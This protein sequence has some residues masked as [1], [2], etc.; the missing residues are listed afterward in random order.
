MKCF[1]KKKVKTWKPLVYMWSR[2]CNYKQK[3]ESM[4]HITDGLPAFFIIFYLKFFDGKCNYSCIP[5]LY[6]IFIQFR[7][8]M[9]RWMLW[10]MMKIS[11]NHTICMLF[12]QLKT[13]HV[14][15]YFVHQLNFSESALYIYV[16]YKIKTQ[17]ISNT[18]LI[19]TTELQLNLWE[20]KKSNDCHYK[21]VVR[22]KFY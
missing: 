19:R 4:M 7:L 2:E 6:F 20:Q 11:K 14:L 8:S 13:L 9:K 12:A 1:E 10:W 18:L 15:P 3:P 16:L 5:F 17:I 21:I 22:I